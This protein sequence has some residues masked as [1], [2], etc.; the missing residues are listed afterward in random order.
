MMPAI[1][2]LP[3]FLR[4]RPESAPWQPGNPARLAEDLRETQEHG[5]DLARQLTAARQFADIEAAARAAAERRAEQAEAA[6]KTAAEEFTMAHRD[7]RELTDVCGRLETANTCLQSEITGLR[8]AN[9]GL[10]KQLANAMGYDDAALNAIETGTGQP[11][12]A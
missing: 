6:H 4:R 12:K 11:R 2:F 8:T 5:A 10:Q 9:A 3:A 1:P 7:L